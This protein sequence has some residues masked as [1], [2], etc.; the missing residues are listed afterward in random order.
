MEYECEKLESF[1]YEIRYVYDEYAERHGIE[2]AQEWTTPTREEWR[3][4]TGTKMT[5]ER[6]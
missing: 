4:K 6:C 1:M 3:L 2:S 5:A